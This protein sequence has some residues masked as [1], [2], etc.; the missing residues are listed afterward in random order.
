VHG[1]HSLSAS[2][3]RLAQ[4]QIVNSWWLLPLQL[5]CF[6]F[7]ATHVSVSP[8]CNTSSLIHASTPPPN[9]AQI[10][11]HYVVRQTF[12]LRHLVRHAAWRA[13]AETGVR[14]NDMDVLW[15]ANRFGPDPQAVLRQAP[16]GE[17]GG[18]ASDDGAKGNKEH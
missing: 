12:L 10:I 17:V 2:S 5:F 4:N 11:H 13:M 7:G 6:D 9:A 3:H 16:A 8:A 15:R 14:Q 1:A 18:P